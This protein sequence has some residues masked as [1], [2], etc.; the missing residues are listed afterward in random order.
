MPMTFFRLFVYCFKYS[1]DD[2]MKSYINRGFYQEAKNLHRFFS[3]IYYNYKI[4]G[5]RYGNEFIILLTDLMIT[6][7]K[8]LMLFIMN[9]LKLDC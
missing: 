2:M 8:V 9:I 6:I 3:K 5:Y 1:D 7:D 4:D